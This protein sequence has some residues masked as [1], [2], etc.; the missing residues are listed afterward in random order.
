MKNKPMT[1]KEKVENILGGFSDRNRE[2]SIGGSI[3]NGVGGSTIA[4]FLIPIDR[5]IESNE[6]KFVLR[7]GMDGV[8][9]V[10]D[11]IVPYDEVLDCYEEKDEY[12]QQMVYVILKNGMRIDF[13]CVGIKI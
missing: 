11:I 3:R 5:K 8:K 1:M 13:E 4:D 12:N 2:Y 10:N 6:K 7:S 9:N